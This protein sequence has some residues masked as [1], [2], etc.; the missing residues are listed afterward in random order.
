MGDTI[1][2]TKHIIATP[3]VKL[4]LDDAKKSCGRIRSMAKKKCDSDA[5]H[6]HFFCIT[7]GTTEKAC[8][9]EKMKGAAECKVA[10]ETAYNKC[11]SLWKRAK[12]NI[13]DARERAAAPMHHTDEM[14]KTMQSGTTKCAGLM[15]D[16]NVS[17]KA[18]FDKYH[19]ICKGKILEAIETD[20]L[21]ESAAPKA[22]AKAAKTLKKAEAKVAA[23]AG[24]KDE[25]KKI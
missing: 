21:E 13:H 6:T 3:L 22:V 14:V 11:F 15:K 8:D 19:A 9:T 4:T 12:K 16:A 7:E 10:H 5:H 24:K 18:A 1:T 20:F 25:G 17:C 2:E 23:K